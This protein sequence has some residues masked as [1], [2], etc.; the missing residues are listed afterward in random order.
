MMIPQEGKSKETAEVCR[1]QKRK[2]QKKPE[3]EGP[4]KYIKKLKEFA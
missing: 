3:S 4:H 2:D 1:T